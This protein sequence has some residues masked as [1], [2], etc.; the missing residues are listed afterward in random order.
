LRNIF[1]GLAAALM[2]ATPAMAA[3]DTSK[4]NAG[5]AIPLKGRISASLDDVDLS[6][7]TLR[8]NDQ[9]VSIEK[10]GTFSG[11]FAPTRYYQITISGAGIFDSVQTFGITELHDATCQCLHM[12]AIDV[13][14][15][16]KGRVELFF[17]GDA[18]A[19]RRYSTPIWQ[20]QRLVNPDAPY[21][22][23]VALL[24]PI[25][26]Y[27][28]TADLASVNLEAVLSDVDL[29]I[30]PPK[31]VVFYSPPE[32]AQ[33]LAD[34]G[35]DYVSLGNNHSYDYLEA[36]LKT[37]I[38]AIEK[39]GLRWSGAG[40]DE[41]EALQAARMNAAGSDFAMLG[42]VGWK[43]RVQPNQV[44]EKDKG[45][46]AHGTITN[47]R[48]SVN[49]EVRGG[50][51]PI[52][53]LHASR[54]YS[55]APTKLSEQRMRAAIDA[56][57]L[58]VASHHPHVTQGLERYGN[59]LIAYS[60]GNFLFD[61]Y[62]MLTHASYA[63]K[64]WVEDGQLL[65]AEII[66]L[67]ILDYRPVPAIGRVRE[68]VLERTQR[69]SKE[70][71]TVLRRNGGHLMLNFDG[72]AP[73]ARAASP[74][75]PNQTA[76]PRTLLYW[77]DF[78]NSVYGE[79]MDRTLQISGANAGFAF[80]NVRGTHMAFTALKGGQFSIQPSTFFR[81]LSNSAATVSLRLR[82]NKPLEISAL[83]QQRPKGMARFKALREA[84]FNRKWKGKTTASTDWQKVEFCLPQQSE[85]LPYRLRLS[86]D[87]IGPNKEEPLHAA[88]DNLT[89]KE[90]C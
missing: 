59:G 82:S 77:G 89:I 48:S 40:Y 35:F 11:A 71:G 51:T 54:E 62:F 30:T 53:Q 68:Y 31:S 45:G 12:P 8:I 60:L 72:P 52:A 22:D 88:I 75:L 47:I 79:A 7:L 18:M 83:L 20:E 74:S 9:A 63:L 61:Q 28:E 13:L 70:R 81:T 2:L 49:R 87:A 44:A 19:G 5:D 80:D 69:L 56:G 85:L 23:L 32:L 39:A 43:G 16:K 1:T 66:P 86:F 50:F 57:A 46:A 73:I 84:A 15:R 27:V 29:G 36:G 21:A 90:G 67:R 64:I 24:K 25:K 65:R 34:T 17:A 37:T 78:E 38:T 14:A 10:D 6:A 3:P 26:P 42:Y 76:T 33:A 55:D 41:S 58:I 4:H